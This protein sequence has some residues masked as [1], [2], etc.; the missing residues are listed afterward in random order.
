MSAC[1]RVRRHGRTPVVRF[2]G[3][4]TA[5]IMKEND[6]DMSAVDETARP[7]DSAKPFRR[8]AWRTAAERSDAGRGDPASG[9]GQWAADAG[10]R[11]LDAKV[12]FSRLSKGDKLLPS[13]VKNGAC[14]DDGV[15][16][17][18]GASHVE[19]HAR[20]DNIVK[21]K[22]RTNSHEKAHRHPLER[23]AG[24]WQRLARDRQAAA[25]VAGEPDGHG[26]GDIVSRGGSLAENGQVVGDADSRPGRSGRPSASAWRPAARDEVLAWQR[27]SRL[28]S[29]SP[30]ETA[31]ESAVC[32]QR[33]NRAI[34]ESGFCSR[35]KAD[36][37]I[38]SG[39][40]Q[41]N[42]EVETHAGRRVL[43]EDVIAV[44]GTPLPGSQSKL[45][46]MLHKPVQV[47]STASDP[48]G[49]PTVLSLL[50]REYAGTRLFPVGRLDYFSEGL[51][52]LT[53]D[54]Q[55]SQR[56]MHPRH[57]LV[58]EYEVIVRDTVTQKALQ[59]MRA[60]MRLAE[61]E[62]LRPVEVTA[63]SMASGC[64]Q[65]RMRLRQGVNRQIRRMCRDLGL[66]ILRLRRVAIGP[67]QLG[68]LPLGRCR[69]LR[70][71]ELAALRQAVGLR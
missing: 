2:D 11:P 35:R 70:E 12:R 37:L 44:D 30:A 46:I 58:K 24:Q 53:N 1:K 18:N 22:K 56:L 49:R 40:V 27:P 16:V 55:L 15:V 57:H 63:R 52:L 43:P 38:F 47:V 32:A 60:G 50:P 7:G 17:K 8:T 59:T 54:G 28:P 71:D 19:E 3:R 9:N 39:R 51:I 6:A 36:E 62:L 25:L 65:L 13:H 33:L 20:Y 42:G 10:Q 21:V 69:P 29:P 5:R 34:A 31:A 26:H 68:E 4:A 66:T 45:H 61:G 64:T 48:D 23:A 41:V 14:C 67:L